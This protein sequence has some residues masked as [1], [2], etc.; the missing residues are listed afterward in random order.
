MKISIITVCRNS[1]NTIADT[2]RSVLSQDHPDIEY[3]LIDGGSTDRTLEIINAHR[4]KIAKVVS[5]KDG[6]IYFA[7]NKGLQLATG[8]LVGLLHA[9]D[10][11]P[12][13]DILSKVNTH[14]STNST[15]SLY[16]DLQYVSRDNIEKV[17]RYWK[18]GAYHE[19][20]FRKGWMPPH[21]TFFVKR[22][23]YEKYGLFN[24]SLVSAA[25]Y[26]LM[27]RML[28]KNRIS[29][30]YLPEVLVKM[31][32]GGMSNLSLAN[33][34]RANKEDRMAWKLNGLKPAMF[35]LIRK[36]LSKIF[37]FLK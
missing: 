25:D 24:T 16:G 29:V 9:D 23:C 12:S 31:R 3:I 22:A 15:D 36:P 10:I 18:A 32:Q 5:E 34:I 30:C 14:I 1:E 37:Q 26:E 11:Y 17:I 33:R 35:T 13:N 6:G 21:P 20:I 2:I 4:D 8:E 19:G 28:H 7:L 27:L